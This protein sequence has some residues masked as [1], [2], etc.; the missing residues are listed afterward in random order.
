MGKSVKRCETIQESRKPR[1]HAT[2]LHPP[3]PL[4]ATER[5]HTRGRACEGTDA[6]PCPI[7]A[8]NPPSARRM[9]R[10]PRN[11]EL[12]SVKTKTI[13]VVCA[14]RARTGPATT[15]PHAQFGGGQKWEE[16]TF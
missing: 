11:A 9:R 1:R 7:K 3:S 2:G 13:L 6:K 4:G 15:T 8:E 5:L 16:T 10:P 12:T 14:V